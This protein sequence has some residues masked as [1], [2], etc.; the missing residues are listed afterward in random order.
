MARNE[1]IPIRS[2][3]EMEVPPCQ[4]LASWLEA[5]RNIPAA[6]SR[7]GETGIKNAQEFVNVSKAS[8]DDESCFTDLL[9]LKCSV[10]KL[11]DCAIAKTYVGGRE[12]Q[13]QA[14]RTFRRVAEIEALVEERQRRMTMEVPWSPWSDAKLEP[15]A[16]SLGNAVAWRASSPGMGDRQPLQPQLDSGSRDGD[17]SAIPAV[18]TPAPTRRPPVCS[19]CSQIRSLGHVRIC[20]HSNK[21]CSRCRHQATPTSDL[22]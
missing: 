13:M 5:N 18:V 16:A 20:S 3:S 1:R 21:T 2:S 22:A 9:S 17:E 8:A 15:P 6:S 7:H 12:Q 10:K 4:L 14:A 19:C 11:N